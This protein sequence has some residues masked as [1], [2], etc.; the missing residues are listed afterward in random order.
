M[1]KDRL[2]VGRAILIYRKSQRKELFPLV[3]TYDTF[4]SFWTT[5]VVRTFTFNNVRCKV[6]KSKFINTKQGKK[7]SGGFNTET[8][9]CE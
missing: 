7:F 4:H 6:K 2:Q 5:P 3:S 1:F 8:S 9:T